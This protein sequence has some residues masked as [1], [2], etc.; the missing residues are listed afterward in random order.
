MGIKTLTQNSYFKFQSKYK[1]RHTKSYISCRC[2]SGNRQTVFPSHMGEHVLLIT[3]YS[4]LY[5]HRGEYLWLQPKE[6][7]CEQRVHDSRR[8]SDSRQ[9]FALFL[10][11]GCRISHITERTQGGRRLVTMNNVETWA[12][13]GPESGTTP[14]KAEKNFPNVK[15]DHSFAMLVLFL[16]YC[17]VVEADACLLLGRV[18]FN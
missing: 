11:C 7:S 5:F 9:F 16:Y 17:K 4:R 1:W 15:A 18:I 2:S 8:L 12:D 3:A 14:E 10:N 6:C 13:S